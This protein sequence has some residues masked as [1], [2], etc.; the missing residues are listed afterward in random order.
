MAFFVNYLFIY[1]FFNLLFFI[2]HANYLAVDSPRGPMAVSVIRDGNVF[3]A[4]VRTT[5]VCYFFVFIAR[6]FSI[7]LFVFKP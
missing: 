2:E 6:A 3:K 5:Q 1:V 4:L 7:Y